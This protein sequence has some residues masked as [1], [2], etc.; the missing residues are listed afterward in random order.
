M[1]RKVPRAALIVTLALAACSLDV[2][3]DA[4]KGIA[5]FLDAVRTGDRK[6]FEASIDRAALRSDLRD[7]L[8]ELG[9]ANGLDVEGGAS[10]FALDR[11][12][13]PEAFKLVEAKTGEVVPVAP[14][15]AQVAVLMKVRDRA[16]VCLTNPGSATCVLTFTKQAGVWR[17]SGMQAHEMKIELAP[18]RSKPD[19]QPTRPSAC[20]CTSPP[21]RRSRT[22]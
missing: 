3:A 9:R 15:A 7:Q 22:T 4:S 13:T 1:L 14:T 8:A 2:R 18:A 20:C 6:T 12:I 11:R 17:L 16:H 5:R 19:G 10:D 21:G